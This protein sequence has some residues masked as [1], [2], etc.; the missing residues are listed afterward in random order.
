[1]P[2][3]VLDIAERGVNRKGIQQEGA[4][5]CGTLSAKYLLSVYTR[6]KEAGV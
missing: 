6:R 1:M 2:G 3:L 4:G 5:G